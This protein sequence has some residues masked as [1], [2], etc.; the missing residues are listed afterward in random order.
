MGKTATLNLRV[1]PDVK[2]RAEE[3][4][5]TLGVPMSTAVNIFLNQVSLTGGIPFTVSLPKAPADVDAGQMTIDELHS[6]LD[7]GYQDALAGRTQ[8]AQEAFSAF[9]MEN[10]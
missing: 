4:L 7:R 10:E 8:N 2:Q 5:N 3:V 1:S 9:R 6:K